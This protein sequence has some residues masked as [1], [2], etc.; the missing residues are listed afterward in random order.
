MNITEKNVILTTFQRV[1]FIY[2]IKNF[3]NSDT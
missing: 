1:P 2:S 3:S